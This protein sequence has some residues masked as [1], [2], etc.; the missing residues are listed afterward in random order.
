MAKQ[1]RI[2]GTQSGASGWIVD[3]ASISMM[4]TATVLCIF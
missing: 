1:E 4:V 2:Y 3:A